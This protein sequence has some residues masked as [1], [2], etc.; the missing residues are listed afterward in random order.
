[1]SRFVTPGTTELPLE[2]G[3]VLIVR[4]RLNAGQLR[5]RAAR[6][7]E[8]ADDG[9]APKVRLH[10]IGRATVVAYLVDWRLADDDMPIAGLDADDLAAVLDNLEGPDFAEILAAIAAHEATQDAKRAEQKKTIPAGEPRSPRTSR[11]RVAVIGAMN[12]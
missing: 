1:M 3:D 4:T 11:S 2:N 5:A 8:T 10:E 6:M 7:Y 12:G 9:T